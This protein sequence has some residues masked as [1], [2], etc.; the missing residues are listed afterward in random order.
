METTFRNQILLSLLQPLGLWHL[1]STELM[2]DSLE[3]QFLLSG[4]ILDGSRR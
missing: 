1:A 4:S 3:M 2:L